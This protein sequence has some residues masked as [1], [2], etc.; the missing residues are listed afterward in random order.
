MTAKTATVP[1]GE[2]IMDSQAD[3]TPFV[4]D[5]SGRDIFGEAERIRALGPVSRLASSGVG[6]C[7]QGGVAGGFSVV[8]S[9]VSQLSPIAGSQDS[10]RSPLPTSPVNTLVQVRAPLVS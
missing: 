9:W 10:R 1:R 5:P 4:I 8:R 7:Y 6:P 3:V 2:K